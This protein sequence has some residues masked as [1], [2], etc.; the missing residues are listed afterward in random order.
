M[1]S[2]GFMNCIYMFNRL[3]IQVHQWGA[4]IILKM[5]CVCYIKIYLRTV[6]ILVDSDY[7]CKIYYFKAPVKINLNILNHSC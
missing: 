4:K 7:D 3:S 1:I 2:K 5:C 6:G